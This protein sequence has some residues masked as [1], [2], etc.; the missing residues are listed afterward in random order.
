MNTFNLNHLLIKHPLFQEAASRVDDVVRRTQA[1]EQ[2]I[3]PLC[4][5]S[6]AGK[7]YATLPAQEQFPESKDGAKR[8]VPWLYIKMSQAPSLSSL[9]RAILK[10]AGMGAWASRHGGPEVLTGYAQDAVSRLGVRFLV[11][12]EF[13]HYAEKGSKASALDAANAV[14]NFVD[15]SGLSCILPGLPSIMALLNRDEQLRARALAPHH[16]LPYAW[17]LDTHRADFEQVIADIVD[18]LESGGFHVETDSGLALRLYISTAG[19]IGM[20]VKLLNEACDIARDSR[21][22]SLAVM[23]K[24]HGRAVR[25]ETESPN[26]FTGKVSDADADAAFN[27]IMYESGYS[28]EFLTK[29]TLAEG[30]SE[31]VANR[32][33]KDS[34]KAGLKKLQETFGC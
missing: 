17:P 21:K 29:M 30:G 7:T 18:Y 6:R 28:P 26:P 27:K 5:P 22:I 31:A 24:A 14:K 13:H 3:L 10:A 34:N 15:Q 8:T 1:G 2:L 16:F 23:R 9:P 32:F 25:H 12:D 4:G 19:R 20:V 33:L 11:I